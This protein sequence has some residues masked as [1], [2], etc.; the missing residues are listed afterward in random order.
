MG[1]RRD[2]GPM[3]LV[4]AMAG[5]ILLF[6][7]YLASETVGNPVYTPDPKGIVLMGLAACAAF[8]ALALGPIGRAIGRRLLE[9]EA[10]E[11]GE[12]DEM[13][14]VI[15]HLERQLAET[16]DRLD[17]AERLLTEAREAR[18]Q[19]AAPPTRER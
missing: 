9:G 6:L 5:G 12:L 8:S 2:I 18:G 19:V 15:A 13:R 11:R 4:A 10:P 16:Q 7:G 3:V 14:D 17:F 1:L